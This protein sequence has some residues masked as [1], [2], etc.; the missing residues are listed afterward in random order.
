MEASFWHQKWEKGEIAFHES[1][2]NPLL[3]SHFELAS[4]G[5]VLVPLC[6]KTRDIAWLLGRGCRVV[7]VELSEIAVRDLF[8]ELGMTPEVTSAGS[9]LRY[10]SERLEVLVGDVLAVREDLL[11]RVDGVYDR[12]ALVALPSTTRT[13]YAAHLAAVTRGAPQWLVTLEFDQNQLEGPP[14]SLNRDELERLYAGVTHLET[15]SI[16]GGL[17]GR[18]EATESIWRV[19]G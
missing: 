12:A 2:F 13:A 10:Q 19:F 16:V 1:D 17:K 18:V 3:V 11:G 5:R 8:D 7:G 9:F 4:G 14:F 6:G 15:R